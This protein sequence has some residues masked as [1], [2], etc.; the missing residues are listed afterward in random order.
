M[1]SKF[2]QISHHD[3]LEV[4]QTYSADREYS[5]RIISFQ[6]GTIP[7][8]VYLPKMSK[9]ELTTLKDLLKVRRI[10]DINYLGALQSYYVQV[11]YV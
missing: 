10:N 5:V 7:T 6:N 8:Y 2:Y 1:K 4:V 9:S 3:F 11:F